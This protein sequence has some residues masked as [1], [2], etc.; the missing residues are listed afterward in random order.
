MA[1]IPLMIDQDVESGQLPAYEEAV[2]AR[3]GKTAPLRSIRHAFFRNDFGKEA[4]A[5]GAVAYA[6]VSIRLGFLRKVLGILSVQLLLTTVCSVTLYL[7]PNFRYFL[8][9]MPWLVLLLVISSV[10]LLFAVYVN[11]HIVPLNYMLLAA[12]T[13]CQAV[14]VGFVVSFYDAEMVME[15]VGLT[16]V[17]VFGLFAYALQSKRDFQKHWAAL[18]CFS[19]IFITASFVQLFIQS[20]PFDLAMAIG[21]AVLFSVYLIFDMDRIMHHSSPEDYIDACISVY[22]DIINLFLRILQIIGEMNRH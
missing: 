10:I 19:M 17:V 9:M 20:P 3:Q 14:T 4:A 1:T 11:A 7:I 2:D 5:M 13:C 15:A 12:W 22:L 6:N 8:Q 16:A 21:G 18:F